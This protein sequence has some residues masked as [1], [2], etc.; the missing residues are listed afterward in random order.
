MS[1]NTKQKYYEFMSVLY[2][3]KEFDI[4]AMRIQH[5]VG[6]RIIT[7][8][9]EHRMIK[10]YDDVTRWIGDRP[11]QAMANAFTKE[12]L[13]Q[14]RIDNAQSRAGEKQLTIK[15]LKRVASLVE[16]SVQTIDLHEESQLTWMHLAL[17]FCAGILAGGLIATIWK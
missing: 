2:E 12:C 6:T 4:T 11:T 3:M 8:M 10:R 16:P 9:R 13:K 17:I 15:P 7:L 14:S 5:K 1:K